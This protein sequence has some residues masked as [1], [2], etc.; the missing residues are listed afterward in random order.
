[1]STDFLAMSVDLAVGNVAV[2]GG[3]FGSVVVRDGELVSTGVNLV[4]RSLDPTAHAE[5]VA[6]RAACQQLGSFSLAGCDLYASCEPCPMCLASAL[7]AR[8]D[9]VIFAADRY[10]AAEAGFDD[11]AFYDLFERTPRDQWTTPVAKT[12]HGD[13]FA[14]FRA[15][16]ENADR[17]EY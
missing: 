1:M 2:G 3:P 5:V 9:R 10:E 13:P 11:L 6:I 15:W 8:V 17:T 12:P 14:P 7:W 4:T 16:A